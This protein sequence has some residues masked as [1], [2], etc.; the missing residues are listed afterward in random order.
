M[1]DHMI[2]ELLRAGTYPFESPE[3]RERARMRLRAAIAREEAAPTRRHRRLLALVAAAAVAV[4]WDCSL[5]FRSY[6]LRDLG[7]LD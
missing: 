7:V 6:F 3:A 5:P 4:A 1:N 2:G